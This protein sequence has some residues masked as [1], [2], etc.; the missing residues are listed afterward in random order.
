MTCETPSVDAGRMRSWP[1]PSSTTC[2]HRKPTITMRTLNCRTTS[3]ARYAAAQVAC[4]GAGAEQDDASHVRRAAQRARRAT[5]GL[6]YQSSG[7]PLQ[8]GRAPPPG[9]RR[10][11][12][13][14]PAND[15][16]RILRWPILAKLERTTN[17][18]GSGRQESSQ[19][20]ETPERKLRVA[21]VNRLVVAPSTTLYHQ[22]PM[23]LRLCTLTTTS[24]SEQV[25]WAQ[26]P[27]PRHGA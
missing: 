15:L 6:R 3:A 16:T 9:Y 21:L 19:L 25:E 2:T 4:A 20:G 22:R 5:L 24:R 14:A 13:A 26:T 8:S 17:S 12:R 11:S 23:R 7:F 27:G 10:R 18:I 1:G